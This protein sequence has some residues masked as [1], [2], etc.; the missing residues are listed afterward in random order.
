MP[1]IICGDCK[2]KYSDFAKE[3]PECARPTITQNQKIANIDK[4]RATKYRDSYSCR[5]YPEPKYYEFVINAK[6]W[7]ESHSLAPLMLSQLNET[8]QLYLVIRKGLASDDGIGNT[9]DFT[10]KCMGISLEESNEIFSKICVLFP[11]VFYSPI[12][13]GL[14][15]YQIR[16]TARKLGIN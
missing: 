7:L 14:Y 15:L 4:L 3:C 8:E 10:C 5:P 9:E 6:K 16:E 2:K 12:A 11:N 13:R 1:L